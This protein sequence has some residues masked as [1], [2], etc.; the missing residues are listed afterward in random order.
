MR[1]IAIG[2]IH[3]CL[4]SLVALVKH[5]G[6]TDDDTI[7]TLGDYVD[8]GPDS[9]GVIDYLLRLGREQ[10][11]VSLL[12]N[13]E[14]LMLGARESPQAL[15][16]W[17]QDVVGGAAT[18]E[19]YGLYDLGGIPPHH[20]DF[21]ENCLPYHETDSH[22]FVHANADPALPLD[23]QDERHLYWK[24]FGEPAPH[25]S[26]KVMVCGHTSQ[27]SGEP[28]DVGHAVCIDTRAYGGGWLT[29]YDPGSGRYWQTNEQGR[30][31]EGQ[32]A[33]RPRA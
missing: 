29:A 30:R 33:S 10:R 1:T 7:V 25:R 24:R 32:I 12:G 26:G 23:Q 14:L 28:L 21:I 13:H 8:R 31:R 9:R 22:F 16:W 15:D 19:S 5:A 3:G 4:S 2:D 18:L 27:S 6:I 17:Q 11:V 20:W